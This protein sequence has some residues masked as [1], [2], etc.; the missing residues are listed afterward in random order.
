MR[1]IKLTISAFGPYA[2]KT[3]FDLDRFGQSGLYLITGDTGAGKTTIFDAVT[4]ALYGEASGD[5]RNARMLRS[6]YAKDTV[7]TYAELEFECMGKRYRVR[8]SPEYMRAKKNGSG[9]TKETAK[10]ELIFPDSRRPLVKSAEVTSAIV[11][12]TGINRS[13]F[14]QISMLAQGEFQQLLL[15][16][17]EDRQK[18][19]RRIFNTRLYNV[20]Q[21]RLKEEASAIK[22]ELDGY[23]LR[24]SGYINGIVCKSGDAAESDAQKAKNGEMTTPEIIALIE[25]ITAQD[26]AE[27]AEL[28]RKLKDI[29]DKLT[30]V[31]ERLG[32]A[33]EREKSRQSLARAAAE[34]EKA[35]KNTAVLQEAAEKAE[36]ALRERDTLS[37]RITTIKNELAGYEQLERDTKALNALNNESAQLKSE[38]SALSDRHGQLKRDIETGRQERD[39]LKNAAVELE[40]HRQAEKLQRAKSEELKALSASLTAL[41]RLK[42]QC[43]KA[44]ADYARART[45]A[46][47][48]NDRYMRLNT[49]YLDN[50]AGL[51]ADSLLPGKPCPVCGSTAHPQPA[52]KTEHAP[53]KEELDAAQKDNEDA[54]AEQSK[55]SAAAS[56]LNGRYETEENSVIS[57][58]S[59]F[60][61]VLEISEIKLRIAD[62]AEAL[63]KE[64]TA[65]EAAIMSAERDASELAALEEKLPVAEKELERCGALIREKELAAAQKA[66]NAASLDE[67]VRKSRASLTFGGIGEAEDEI[68]RCESEIKRLQT[69]HDNAQRAF[70]ESKAESVSLQGQIKAL[71]EGLKGGE[72]TDISALEAEKKELSAE[73]AAGNVQ[74]DAVNIRLGAN[75]TALENITK[76]NGEISRLE[77]KYIWLKALDDTAR[78]NLAGKEKIELETYIQMTYFDRIIARANVRLMRMTGGQYELMRRR[79]AENNKSQSG[80]ELDVTDHANGTHRSVKTLSGGESFKASLSLALGLSDEI[81]RSSGGIQPGAMFVDEGFGSL[82]DESLN[83]AVKTLTELSDS[84]RIIGIISH[85]DELKQRIERQIVVRKSKTGGSR[86]EIII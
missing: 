85:V 29:E 80:L 38:C 86:A 52:Q 64:L 7:P 82:D 54:Q 3:E 66:A 72:D 23:M 76:L 14:R 77:E 71:S 16:G 61:G 31:N 25:R 12:I 24:R 67:A 22:R 8:R 19:F 1:P 83:Q 43:D 32:K 41:S 70:E 56:R 46:A 15:A 47:E 59:S 44:A 4:Y 62:A 34:L 35:Q 53:S 10:A 55:R 37:E 17:T 75:R 40:K 79:T 60:F 28:E 18:I 73:K 33:A 20:L 63:E 84:H 9:L 49:A 57:A 26:E 6:K 45:D 30:S 58:A 68:S 39:R 13:Q 42:K 51:L 50:Q 5:V 21:D 65:L 2:D 74:R 81:Q 69:A 78:G 27:G 11:E 36:T 48:A